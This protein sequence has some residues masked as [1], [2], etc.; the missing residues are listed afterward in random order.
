MAFKMIKMMYDTGTYQLKKKTIK[1]ELFNH[2]T[3]LIHIQ[4]SFG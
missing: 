4:I 3:K 2:R 1:L